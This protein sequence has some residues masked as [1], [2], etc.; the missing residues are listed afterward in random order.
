MSTFYNLVDRNS[1]QYLES[2]ITSLVPK[3]IQELEDT[4]DEIWQRELHPDAK[5]DILFELIKEEDSKFQ[6]IDT[7]ELQI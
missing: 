5:S 6:K 3:R 7:E 1:H 2:F 4:A